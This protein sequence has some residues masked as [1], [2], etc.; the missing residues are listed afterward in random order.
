MV[1]FLMRIYRDMVNYD[2]CVIK[3]DS[4]IDTKF[5]IWHNKYESNESFI[6]Q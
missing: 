5:I 4:Y 2:I 3:D 6:D 1:L